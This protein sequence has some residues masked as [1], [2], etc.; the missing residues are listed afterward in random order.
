MAEDFDYQAFAQEYAAR[1]RGQSPQ[2]QGQ[3][4]TAR[5]QAPAPSNV[6]SYILEAAQGIPDA[7]P[8]VRFGP[9]GA[10]VIPGQTRDQLIRDLQATGAEQQVKSQIDLQAAPIEKRATLLS[11]RQLDAEQNFRK[12]VGQFA[13]LIAQSKAKMQQQGGEG[14]LSAGLKGKAR[15]LM[16]DPKASAIAAFPGQVTETT[17]ALNPVLTG[18][19]RVIKGITEKISE[20]L[21]G[22]YD[23]PTFIAQKTAQSLTNAYRITK[24]MNDLG[25]TPETF[26][27]MSD[28]ELEAA[29]REIAE[30]AN[31]LFLGP[32]EEQ[33]IEATIQE[34][35]ST[36]PAK[37]RQLPGF[38]VDMGSNPQREAAKQD[39]IS[40]Y[41]NLIQQGNNQ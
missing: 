15:V 22:E 1:M 40:R 30:E 13:S 11:E 21:P 6:P 35:L 37:I 5:P 12:V 9:S 23:P 24:A 17:L 28:E 8:E 14:G 25:I 16:K 33:Y 3:V 34:V 38:E 20:T 29:G 27:D 31:S 19:N 26:V 2:P 7:S 10:T 18:Q 4:A 39:L 41:Q 36:P 32:E